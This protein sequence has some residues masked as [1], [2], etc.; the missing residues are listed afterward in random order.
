MLSRIRRPVLAAA[1][2]GAFALP[3]S[4]L[5][6]PEQSSGTP[7]P[8]GGTVANRIVVEFKQDASSTERAAGRADAQTSLVRTLGRTRFQLVRPQPGQSVADALAALRRDPNV[9]TAQ[10]DGYSTL[11]ATT[12]DPFF[13]QLWGLQNTGLGVDGFVGA[14]AGDDVNALAAWDRTRGTPST[15]IADIDS[16]YRYD[17][18]DLAPVA[19]TNPGEIPG[20]GI[21]DDGNGFVD[22]VHGYDFVGASADSPS[23]DSDPTDD[24]LVSG[25]HGVHTAGTMGAAGNNGI[26]ISGVAQNVRIMALRVCADSPSN[27]DQ[28]LC[29]FSSQ[30]AAINYAGLMRARAANMSLGGTTFSTAVLDALASNP[31]TLYVISAGNDAES[32]DAVPHYPCNYD[33]ST[34]GI[35][36]AVDNVVCVAATDQADRLASFSDW[37]ATSVDLGAPGTEIYSTY[38]ER[39]DLI[40][41]DFETNDFASTWSNTGGLGLQ[42][43]AA[44]DGPLTSFGMTDSPGAAPAAST[45]YDETMTTG[46]AIPAGTGSCQL[47]GLRRIE[48]GS[49]GSFFYEVLSDGSSV[50]FNDTAA[51]TSGTGM[52]G[53]ITVPITGLAGTTVRLHFDFTSGS[54]PASTDGLWLDDLKLTC[55]A[56]LSTPPAYAFLQGTSM[57][58]PQVTGAAGLLFSLKPSATVTEVKSAILSSVDPDPALAGITTSGGRL[59]V[60]AAMDKLVPPVVTPPPPPT[61]TTTTTV[62]PPPPP[63]AVHC[64]V[65]RLKGLSLAQAKRALKRAHCALGKV[66]QPRKPKHGRLPALVVKS[67]KPGAGAVRAKGTKV[68]LTLA[69]KPK[70]KPKRRR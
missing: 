12:N 14:V 52:R 6:A 68:A 45:Q 1:L 29:P 9:K 31:G 16:G 19:W 42:R 44:G 61:T 54:S 3:G 23:S 25:G 59:D 15:V 55:Y 24:N 37:G 26:G 51:D 7:A 13:D 60:A 2:L 28:A 4:A 63:P 48:R 17:A 38:P 35:P 69:P 30:I 39:D 34:S 32:N 47:S 10:Q 62:T 49:G 56:P 11:N 8:A 64:K 21:D 57:A 33:P 27:N 70:P 40:S 58:A 53:F 67:S 66:R 36:G 22:D 65:P 20:N 50:F 5:A 41:Q 18:P 43:A 46:V